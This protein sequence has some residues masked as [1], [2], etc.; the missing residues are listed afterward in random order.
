MAPNRACAPLAAS[1]TRPDLEEL[2]SYFWGESGSQ[3]RGV[4]RSQRPIHQTPHPEPD[5]RY[6]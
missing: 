5:W 1:D 2:L 3:V 4:A 6:G